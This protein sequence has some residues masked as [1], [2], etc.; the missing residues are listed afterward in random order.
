MDDLV[1]LLLIMTRCLIQLIR[2]YFVIK[3]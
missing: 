1:G 2:I 3:S